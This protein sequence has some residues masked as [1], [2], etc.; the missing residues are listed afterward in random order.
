MGKLDNPESYPWV[1][2]SF[3]DV[4]KDA[5]IIGN[6]G[7]PVALSEINGKPLGI[8]FSAHWCPP[9]RGFTPKLA[10]WYTAGLKDKMEILFVSSD[11]D[12]KSF[13]EYFAEQPWKAL[14]FDQRDKKEVLSD[15]FGVQGIPTFVVLDGAGNVITKDGRSK[16]TKDTTGSS[17]PEGWLPQPVN[18]CNDNPSALNS[19]VCFLVLNPSDS[20]T[21]AITNVA[22]KHQADVGS[23]DAMTYKFFT[24]PEGDIVGKIRGLIKCQDNDVLVLM[25]L[26]SGGKYKV[27]KGEVTEAFISSQIAAHEAGSIELDSLER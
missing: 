10:E 25:G 26:S 14:A 20:S 16:V 12:Q 3:A 8:Y 22:K 27:L 4:M 9:C 18:D 15:M 1:P 24:V 13:D 7:A 21:A 2:P 23:I 17:F 11:R 6:G 5:Q 19:E